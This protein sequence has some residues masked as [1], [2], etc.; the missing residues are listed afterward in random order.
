MMRYRRQCHRGRRADRSFLVSKPECDVC[1]MMCGVWCD[2]ACVD[3]SVTGWRD[4]TESFRLYLG[5]IAA[6]ALW[7]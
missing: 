6:V 3:V 5:I 1:V 7:G 4:V 2:V